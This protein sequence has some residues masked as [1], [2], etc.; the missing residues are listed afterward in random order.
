MNIRRATASDAP[1]LAKVRVDSWQIAYKG[2][3]PDDFLQKI[4]YQKREEAFRAAIEGRG[5][6]IYLAEVDDQTAGFI[7]I[8]AC[9]DPELDARSCGEIW[10]IYVSPT[11]WRRGIGKRLLQEA[12]RILLARGFGKLVLWVLEGNNTAR[13]FYEAC[14]FTPDGASKIIDLEA[15]LQEIRYARDYPQG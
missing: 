13:S 11:Y 6:E 8:G 14:G 2:L 1:G 7:T 15:P 9:R 12:E 4:T 10:A 3:V 5:D